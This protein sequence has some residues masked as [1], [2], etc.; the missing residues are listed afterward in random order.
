MS[1][2]WGTNQTEK[3]TFWERMKNPDSFN[4]LLENAWTWD[5]WCLQMCFAGKALAHGWNNHCLGNVW[6]PTYAHA[7]LRTAWLAACSH[8]WFIFLT[9]DLSRCRDLRKSNLRKVGHCHAALHFALPSA[10]SRNGAM[11]ASVGVA[12]LPEAQWPLIGSTK[13]ISMKECMRFLAFNLF[14][15]EACAYQP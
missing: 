13:S 8:L 14:Q 5:V 15:F 7:V 9:N 4:A 3:I 11:R 6:M 12:W 10:P 1:F 2:Q